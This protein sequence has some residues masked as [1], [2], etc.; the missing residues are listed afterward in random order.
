MIHLG[1]NLRRQ[2]GAVAERLAIEEETPRKASKD[3]RTYVRV[4]EF[5]TRPSQIPSAI[6]A[7]SRVTRCSIISR[8][9]LRFR[10]LG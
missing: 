8:V 9:H 10:R 7:P 6:R 5:R 1:V 4:P 2:K 3:S